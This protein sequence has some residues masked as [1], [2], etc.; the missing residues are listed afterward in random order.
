MQT[1]GVRFIRREDYEAWFTLGVNCLVDCAKL[2]HERGSLG[3]DKAM[4]QLFFVFCSSYDLNNHDG[5]ISGHDVDL[6]D[7]KQAVR[8]AERH[9]FIS[10]EASAEIIKKIFEIAFCFKRTK[11]WYAS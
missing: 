4:N 3:V 11:E 2:Q 8:Y 6:E 1:E 10:S 7:F 5:T 9:G